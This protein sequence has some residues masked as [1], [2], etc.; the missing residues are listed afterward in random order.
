MK[1]W[2]VFIS[3]A[4]EDKETAAIP[5]ANALMRAG[6][7]VWL[8]KQE[9][10][11]GD[12]LREKIDEGL[13][14]SRFGIVILSPT[15]L[16]KGWPK[17][18][19]DGLIALE[20]TGEKVI[21]PVWHDLDYATLVQYSPILAGRLAAK[22]KEGISEIAKY[23]TRVVF[24]SGDSPSSLHPSLTSR[25]IELIEVQEGTSNV[26]DFLIAHPSIIGRVI[27]YGVDGIEEMPNICSFSPDLR[28][29]TEI[30]YARVRIFSL[31]ILMSSSD[32][33]FEEDKPAPNIVEKV[34]QMK[35]MI[36]EM[37]ARFSEALVEGE[38]TPF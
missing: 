3:H 20:E 38:I 12:S 22:T 36:K 21:L 13:S 30:P 34:L 16:E 23:I 11:I 18:E 29:M 27:D 28:V 26:R 25:F 2:D 31:L 1:K 8:D 14:Q 15:F 6:L 33:I 32:S 35:S 7:R 37:E 17:R 9:M 24:E 5:L 4:S 10:R 19:L